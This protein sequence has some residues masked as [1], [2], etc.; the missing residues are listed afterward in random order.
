MQDFQ[1]L[2]PCL[3]ARLE[4][5]RLGSLKS[6]PQECEEPWK[7]LSGFSESNHH[8]KIDSAV[9]KPILPDMQGMHPN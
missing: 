5:M 6:R 9:K 1:P 7:S 4:V 8:I 3:G 2:F